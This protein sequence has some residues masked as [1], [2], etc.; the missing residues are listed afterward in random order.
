MVEEVEWEQVWKLFMAAL[1]SSSSHTTTFS[2]GTTW[3]TLDL[4][5]KKYGPIMRGGGQRGLWPFSVFEKK[6]KWERVIKENTEH[7]ILTIYSFFIS[8]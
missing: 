4:N 2:S 6:L 1:D 3:D 8:I 5:I 7:I